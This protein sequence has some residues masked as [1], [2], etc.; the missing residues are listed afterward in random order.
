MDPVL[1]DGQGPLPVLPRVDIANASNYKW[2]LNLDGHVAAY[3]LSQLLATNSLVLKQHSPWL[4]YYYRCT[5]GCGTAHMYGYLPALLTTC[6]T[7][8]TGYCMFVHLSTL[9]PAELCSPT[10]FMV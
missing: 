5:L 4:E 10:L 8:F 1:R 3:R 9:R 2:L 6:I 7:V